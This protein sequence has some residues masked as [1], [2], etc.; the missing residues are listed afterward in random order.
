MDACES[1]EEKA[2][3]T[4][5]LTVSS[6]LGN[7]TNVAAPAASTEISSAAVS[8]SSLGTAESMTGTSAA[9]SSIVFSGGFPQ[10]ALISNQ[11]Q[12]TQTSVKASPQA[13]G[14]LRVVLLLT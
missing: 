3:L 7:C 13:S 4:L 12:T 11:G 1:Y 8:S 5:L 9:V 6:L 2:N 14:R 10:L